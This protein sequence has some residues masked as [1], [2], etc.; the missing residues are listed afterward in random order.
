MA[1]SRGCAEVDDSAFLAMAEPAPDPEVGPEPEPEPE[2]APFSSAVLDAF[3]THAEHVRARARARQEAVKMRSVVH[4]DEVVE[5]AS[6]EDG[7][8][9]RLPGD[10]FQGD[11]NMRTLRSLLKMIDGKG[12][13][14]SDHQLAFHTAFEKA[15]ARVLYK[16]DWSTQK[17]LIMKKNGW[18]TCSSEVLIRRASHPYPEPPAL[19]TARAHHRASLAQHASTLRKDLQAP[20]DPTHH[21]MLALLPTPARA[22]AA[23]P[24]SWPASRSP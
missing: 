3:A 20:T 9:K 21:P 18:D 16:S 19:P 17:P 5:Q 13:E 1:T 7:L 11:C 12:F 14:R 24:S 22:A 15:T 2:P 4:D 6:E 8:G 23:S 10:E